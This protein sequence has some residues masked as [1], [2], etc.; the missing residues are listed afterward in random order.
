MNGLKKGVEMDQKATKSVD[1]KERKLCT[2]ENC[3]FS[4]RPPWEK[5]G[6]V[7]GLYITSKIR[8]VKSDEVDSDIYNLE[9]I[10]R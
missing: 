4:F 5:Y 10:F 2:N 6:S 9:K 8:D 7:L 1:I 3:C